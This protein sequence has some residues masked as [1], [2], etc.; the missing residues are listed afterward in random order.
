MKLINYIVLIFT[1]LTTSPRLFCQH[2]KHQNPKT[3]VILLMA[4]DLGWGDVGFNGN[5]NIITPHLDQMSKEGIRFTNFYAAAPLCSPTRASCLTGRNPFRQGIFA[6]HTGAMRHAEKT[7]PEILKKA[8]YQTGFFGKWHLGWIEAEKIESRGHFSPPWQHG[9]DETFAT[10]SAVPT[11]NP[12][13][14]PY[15]WKGFGSKED[16]SWGGSIY[17]H[18]GKPVKDNLDGD[19]S[20]IIMDRAIPFIEKAVNDDKA[21]FAA[22]WFHAPHEPILAGPEYLAKY[23]DLPEGQKHYYGCITAMDEQIGRLRAYLKQ[24]GQDKNTLI[25]FCSDNGPADPVTK[26]GIA[27]AGP[28]RGHKHQMW[29]GGLRVPSIAIWPGQIKSKQTTDYQANTNDYLPTIMDILN[30]NVSK[31]IPLDGVSLKHLLLEGKAPSRSIPY[32]SGYM[33]SYS[34]TELYA[35]IKG[36]YK[37]CIPQQKSEMMLFNLK[38]DPEEKHNLALEKPL[39][40]NEMKSE[41]EKVKQSWRASREGKDYKW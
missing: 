15:N 14:T 24:I 5:K 38:K 37:I 13:Q 11:W 8:G 36:D 1:L 4:D 10:K 25:F 21:F 31:K 3:N 18:N 6:A 12:T 20:R 29:E 7:I 26:K 30:I 19:D 34:G 41:L 28:Y 33:R 39:L 22:I 17:L 16:G 35:Y 40:F 2:P 32:A 9:F 27:S 23:P